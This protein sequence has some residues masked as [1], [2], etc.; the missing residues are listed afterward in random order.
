[1][2][3][4]DLSSD[5]VHARAANGIP[6]IDTAT[7]IRDFPGVIHW[8]MPCRNRLRRVESSSA[9]VAERTFDQASGLHPDAPSTIGIF[10]HSVEKPYTFVPE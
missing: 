6:R 1:M 4:T 7:S 8:S 9:A 10:G 5:L 3:A 2:E